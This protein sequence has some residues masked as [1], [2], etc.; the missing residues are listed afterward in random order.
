MAKDWTLVQDEIHR[1]YHKENKPLVEVMRLVKGK[2]GFVASERSYRTQLV[3]WGYTKYSTQA[4]PKP[5]RLIRRAIHSTRRIHSTVKAAPNKS[6]D[7]Y[8]TSRPNVPFGFANGSVFINP[9]LVDRRHSQAPLDCE[10]LMEDV[11]GR[12]PLHQA[13]IKRDIETVRALLFSDVPINTKDHAGN[14]PLHFAVNAREAEIA[15]LL[16]RFGAQANDSDQGGQSSLHLAVCT[17]DSAM[18]DALIENGADVSSQ[19]NSG[20]TP[21]HL[22][23][24]ALQS[25]EDATVTALLHAGSDTN[26][27]NHDSVTPF[28]QL[29]SCSSTKLK[30]VVAPW[31]P[32]FIS[33][34]A[35]A[36]TALPNGSTPLGIFLSHSGG[37]SFWPTK[38]FGKES[39][40]ALD[41]LLDSGSSVETPTSSERPM[42]IEFFRNHYGRWGTNNELANKLCELSRP[43]HVF[44]AGNTLLHE[45]VARCVGAS[46]K[47]HPGTHGLLRVLVE[48]GADPNHRNEAGQT[49]LAVLF[50]GKNKLDLV[51]QSMEVL[52]ACG[53]NTSLADADHR[54]VV[55]E[56][57]KRYPKASSVLRRLFRASCDL[58]AKGVDSDLLADLNQTEE[59]KWWAQWEVAARNVSWESVKQDVANATKLT[60]V[61]KT[62]I[63]MGY[64]ILAEHHIEG[65]RGQFD[66]GTLNR[67]E[68]RELVAEILQ[69]CR[70]WDF[71]PEQQYWDFLLRLCCR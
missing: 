36:T 14:T 64:T 61:N 15:N 5:N 7:N 51:E 17:A 34:G 18:V 21:L 28:L 4:T 55:F 37:D 6:T 46:S 20:N 1:L 27:P 16:L 60:D 58:V 71:L 12:T 50:G 10:W 52:L 62:V 59:Q 57:A 39:H 67:D 65:L 19:D 38:H 32:I 40:A 41:A 70:D 48:K 11:Q 30:D 66:E 29:L 42:V 24:S 69:D 33:H 31:I 9:L 56:A 2:F 63:A 13:V 49:P 53:A 3:K 26:I 23:I 54:L 45:L 43:G 25:G 68:A 8:P 35:S 44:E 22:A 47:E